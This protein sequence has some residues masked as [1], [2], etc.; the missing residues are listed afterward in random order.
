MS[1]SRKGFK[2]VRVLVVDDYAPIADHL[3][4]VLRDA[5]HEA[6]AVY[7]GDEALRV[8]G[9]FSPHA[10]VTDIMMPGMNG[11]ELACAFGEKFPA[12][13]ALLITATQL[14]PELFIGGLR[15]K[16]LQK[17]FDLSDLFEFLEAA[18]PAYRDR[19]GG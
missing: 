17:P 13:R 11:V 14:M 2:S 12:C 16:V 15:I 10:L 5:G 18:P 6:V 19:G 1:K 7:S 3:A 9:Q 8:A 4:Q